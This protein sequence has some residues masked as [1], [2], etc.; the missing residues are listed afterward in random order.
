MVVNAAGGHGHAHTVST[1]ADSA[2]GPAL[3]KGNMTLGEM[4]EL[5]D[6]KGLRLTRSLG[7]NFLHDGNQL[8]RIVSLAQVKPGDRVLEIGPGLGPLTECLLDAGAQVLAIEKDRRLAELLAE[9]LSGR[10]GLE[11]VVADALDWLRK[12]PTDLGHVPVVANLPY[13]VA[14]P[15]L[16][17]LAHLTTPPPS[18]TVTVQAEV[19]DRVKAAPGTPEYGVL[20]LLLASAFLPGASFRIPANCFFPA[21]DVVST[22]LRLDRRPA[23]L[24][25]GPV[26]ATYARLVKGAFS[27]RRKRAL[28]VLR[29]NWPGPLLDDLWSRLGLSPDARP[30]SL[31]PETFAA[32]ADAAD[33]AGGGVLPIADSR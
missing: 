18:V 6:R 10:P 22:C 8:R 32:L 16:V 4:R 3:K 24:V 11:L 26:Q 30:E 21:P 17:E 7:Q 33:A 28:K 20:T 12:S 1:I 31:S 9:R 27:Q 5:L 23:P 14:S 13:S 19:A 2:R 15:I 29:A 25:A